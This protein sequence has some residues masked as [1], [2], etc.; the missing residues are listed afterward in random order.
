[1]GSN[2]STGGPEI[3][4]RIECSHRGKQ[5]MSAAESA[6]ASSGPRRYATLS[7]INHTDKFNYPAVADK[8]R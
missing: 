4:D 2:T 5:D 8:T 6:A 7:P 3:C 1:M